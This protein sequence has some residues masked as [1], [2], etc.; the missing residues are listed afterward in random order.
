VRLARAKGGI[1]FSDDSHGLFCVGPTGRGAAELYGLGPDALTVTG[2]L[3]KALGCYGGCTAGPRAVIDKVRRAVNY[4]GSTP[5]PLPIAGSCLAALDVIEQEPELL[6]R[7]RENRAKMVAVLERKGVGVVSDE[8]TPIVTMELAGEHQARRLAGHLR[9]NGLIIQ[10]FNYPT[11]PRT[12]L[13]R[14]I[15]RA[16]HTDDV[17]RRFEEALDSFDFGC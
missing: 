15:A 4:V 12:N 7:L 1:V 8:R 10:Y 6:E 13:L 5:M 9:S 3:S 2:S 11:E 16:S 17:I 14:G